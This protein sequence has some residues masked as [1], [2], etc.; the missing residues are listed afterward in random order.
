M[1]G[2]L[3]A[4]AYVLYKLFAGVI[5]GV[6][7]A[8]NTITAPL[9]NLYVRLSTSGSPIPQGIIL[10]PNGETVPVANLQVRPIPGS[11]RATFTYN[12]AT[13]Y[14]NTPHDQYGNWAASTTP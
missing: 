6:A 4:G 5:G 10:L 1:L 9:A 11:N 8:T 12:Y 3:G 2:L 13:Y 7:A 14:L